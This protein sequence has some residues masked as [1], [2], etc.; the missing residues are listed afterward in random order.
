MKKDYKRVKLPTGKV[1]AKIVDLDKNHQ[2]SQE[3]YDK[4]V[5]ED[6]ESCRANYVTVFMY[7]VPVQVKVADDSQ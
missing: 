2:L 1:R 5:Q 4:I 6:F 3:E 7:G